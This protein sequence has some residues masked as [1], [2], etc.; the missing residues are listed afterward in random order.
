MGAPAVAGCP[1]AK[2]GYSFGEEVEFLRGDDCG[3]GVG[4]NGLEAGRGGAV[5]GDDLKVRNRAGQLWKLQ[6][7]CP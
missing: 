2:V 4:E 3:G 6:G 5:V 7:S 1:G